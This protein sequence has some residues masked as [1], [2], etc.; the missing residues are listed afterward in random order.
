MEVWNNKSRA[1]ST[2]TLELPS[3]LIDCAYR[4]GARIGSLICTAR[5]PVLKSLCL[6][7]K[8]SVNLATADCFNDA[9]AGVLNMFARQPF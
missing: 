6:V 2:T 7:G 4:T 3:H 1:R 9:L 8:A 5:M